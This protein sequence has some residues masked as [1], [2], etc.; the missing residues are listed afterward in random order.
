MKEKKRLLTFECSEEF[1]YMICDYYK[2][3]PE[4]LH[5]KEVDSIKDYIYGYPSKNIGIYCK[6]MKNPTFI[7]SYMSYCTC[8]YIYKKTI[9][10]ENIEFQDVINENPLSIT[11]SLN[12]GS[13]QICI[14]FSPNSK[15]KGL[16]THKT[17][18][19]GQAYRLMLNNLKKVYTHDE[20]DDIL[21]RYSIPIDVD[22]ERQVHVNN[23]SYFDKDDD[24]IFMKPNT[25]YCL[26]N[27]YYYDINS[28]YASVLI[29]MFPKAKDIITKIYEERKI[30]PQ[31]KQILNYFVGNLVNH[32]RIGA[33]RWIVNRISEKLIQ[34]MRDVRN[35]NSTIIYANTDGFIVHNPSHTLESSN[36]IG[37]Y[38]RENLDDTVYIFNNTYTPY[39]LIGYTDK[40]G[41]MT[42]KGNCLCSARDKIDLSKG[43]VVD[44][45]RKDTGFSII[46][47]SL[48]YRKVE[49]VE[50]N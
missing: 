15:L 17:I 47:D 34:T 45:K 4:T 27:C 44:Y 24:L 48:S 10:N 19:G 43:I 35:Y 32:E 22:S 25:I 50:V 2:S 7:L 29:E 36:L 39:G 11:K 33:Y 21:Y 1:I 3:N 14:C 16:E 28:A 41:E 12:W 40:N 42:L 49:I 13:Y 30:K 26:K 46:A 6:C 23:Y 20:I 18:N 31:N 37:D 5:F 8:Y 9:E 38:K